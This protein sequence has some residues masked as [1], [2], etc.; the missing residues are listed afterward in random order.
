M[1]SKVSR[2]F[3]PLMRNK[4]LASVRIMNIFST[5]HICVKET[6]YCNEWLCHVTFWC[7]YELLNWNSLSLTSLF[8]RAQNNVKKILLL[9]MVHAFLLANKPLKT[10]Q[11][12]F[13]LPLIV[14]S[15]PCVQSLI[16]SWLIC[17]RSLFLCNVEL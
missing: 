1:T 9:H 16:H 3:L 10:L 15:V 2:D 17:I 5:M 4:V 8:Q 14:G 7:E 11:Y 13:S 12:V 6:L